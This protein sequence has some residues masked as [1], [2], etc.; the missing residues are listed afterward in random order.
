MFEKADFALHGADT[1]E[2]EASRQALARETIESYLT[3]APEVKK[4]LRAA[5]EMIH[6][7]LSTPMLPGLS[8][9]G[10]ARGCT[11]CGDVL[12]N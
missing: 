3:L 11:Q 12:L 8:L 6:H 5:S 10:S 2:A 7:V 4:K 1:P 9:E